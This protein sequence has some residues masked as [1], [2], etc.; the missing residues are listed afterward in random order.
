[1]RFCNNLQWNCNE[2]SLLQKIS[3]NHNKLSTEMDVAYFFYNNTNFL[4]YVFKLWT[5]LYVELHSMDSD[6]IYSKLSGSERRPRMGYSPTADVLDRW[7]FQ[8]F[9]RNTI[10]IVDSWLFV[11]LCI[12]SCTLKAYV[13]ILFS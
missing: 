6:F 10:W 7:Y 1:M 3:N 8:Y 11:N 9:L 4:S 2:Y 13:S 12:F 5:I